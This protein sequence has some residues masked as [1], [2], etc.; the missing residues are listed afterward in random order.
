M[1]KALVASHEANEALV[2]QAPMVHEQPRGDFIDLL[3]QM[4]SSR[5]AKTKSSL[6]GF[7]RKTIALV[8]AS[9]ILGGS[10]APAMAAA[11]RATTP[12]TPAETTPTTTPEG[13]TPSAEEQES[14]DALSTAVD[15]YVAAYDEAE[16]KDAEF[17]LST[18]GEAE[19][20]D[21]QELIDARDTAF[22][23][24]ETAVEGGSTD[25]ELLTAASEHVDNTLAATKAIEKFDES[26]DDVDEEAAQEAKDAADASYSALVE[27]KDASSSTS[28]E[29]AAT[30][31][32]GS[33]DAAED[34]SAP[35]DS[36]ASTA[37][38]VK[39]LKEQLSEITDS[40][41]TLGENPTK[42]DVDQLKSDIEAMKKQLEGVASA[43]TGSEAA[44][45]ASTE[46]PADDSD[47]NAAKYKNEFNSNEALGLVGKFEINPNAPKQS[48]ENFFK[49]LRH[50]PRALAFWK[51][52][53]EN[54]GSYDACVEKP[55]VLAKAEERYHK[56]ASM[57]L[58]RK[59]ELADAVIN[60]FNEDYTY[61]GVIEHNGAYKTVAA[62]KGGGFAPDA[63]VRN[64]DPWLQFVNKKTGETTYI[65]ACDQIVEYVPTPKVVPGST[66]KFTP[67]GTVVIPPPYNPPTGNISN[68]NRPTGSVT[69]PGPKP[70]KKTPR[71]VTEQ[72]V[73]G[74]PGSG[75]HEDGSAADAPA[76]PPVLQE[77][78]D[79]PPATA[80]VTPVEVAPVQEVAVEPITEAPAPVAGPSEPI[81]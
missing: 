34:S 4:E 13:T 46:A 45:S 61:G 25:E 40:L 21:A 51:T 72:T 48:K 80:P 28:E 69:V 77:P 38:Q 17:K 5:G 32:S 27:A 19:K 3:D 37:D 29:D 59:A 1:D 22:T 10:A 76:T 55:G 39:D 75:G 78:A 14:A 31:D 66:I 73:P 2:N 11:E 54:G 7:G 56:Y 52:C 6:R 36:T 18:G 79:N 74:A 33:E 8:T 20:A 49:E 57:P 64:N 24:L 58:E 50:N 44:D 30:E 16:D 12:T 63:N 62:T 81:N 60:H 15:G 71:P 53:L 26:Q 65:R 43:D 35:A 70:G 42:A 23:E 9:A 41:D 67:R 47:F 68:P